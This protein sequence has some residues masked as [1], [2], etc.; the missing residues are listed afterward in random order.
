[1]LVGGVVVVLDSDV[2]P[3][4]LVFDCGVVAHLIV[5]DGGTCNLAHEISDVIYTCTVRYLYVYI[6]VVLQYLGAFRCGAVLI[7]KQWVLSAAHCFHVTSGNTLAPL[8]SY[9]RIQLGTVKENGL[10]PHVVR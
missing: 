9:L 1:M 6:R 7:N 3:Y 8:T 5:L 2:V 4:V 10:S